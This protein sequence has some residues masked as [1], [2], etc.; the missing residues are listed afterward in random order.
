[1]TS[2][3]PTKSEGGV[4]FLR[5]GARPPTTLTVT[6]IDEM[7]DRGYRVESICE[8]LTSQGL[9]VAPW[10]YR[11]AKVRPHSSRDPSDAKVLAALRKLRELDARVLPRP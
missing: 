9:T 8:V 5:G 7:R 4:D 6:F 2:K 1:V 3:R 11:T 10:S